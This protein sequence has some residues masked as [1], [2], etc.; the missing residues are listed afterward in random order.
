MYGAWLPFLIFIFLATTAAKDF[1]FPDNG[2]GHYLT[3]CPAAQGVSARHRRQR[4]AR[5]RSRTLLRLW[6]SGVRLPRHKVVSAIRDLEHHDSRSTLVTPAIRRLNAATT[7]TMPSPPQPWKCR[8]CQMMCGKRAT[9]CPTCGGHWQDVAD[10]TA[11]S[12]RGRSTPMPAPMGASVQSYAMAPSTHVAMRLGNMVRGG[13]AT[14]TSATAL[15][16]HSQPTSAREAARPRA[17]RRAIRTHRQLLL[18]RLRLRAS[19]IPY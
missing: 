4:R 3:V 19:T 11:P 13:S 8:H 17:N 18:H 12:P 6:T 15:A 1:H 10:N 16:T 9:F 14:S 5:T 7:P 2:F